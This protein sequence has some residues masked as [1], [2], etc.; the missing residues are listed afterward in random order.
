MEFFSFFL[1]IQTLPASPGV[2][3]LKGRSIKCADTSHL[4]L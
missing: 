3:P 2:T 4:I 1:N